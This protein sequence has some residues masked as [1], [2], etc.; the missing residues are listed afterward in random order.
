MGLFKKDKEVKDKE[1]MKKKFSYRV[2]VSDPL[3]NTTRDIKTF[4][5]NKTRD[6]DG[7]MWLTNEK[8]EF[9]EIFP[10]DIQESI[11]YTLAEINVKIDKLKK[12]KPKQNE[13][14]LNKEAE[15]FKLY[16]MQRSLEMPEGSFIKI[17]KDGM[18]HLEYVRYKSSFVPL[19]RNL[20]FKTVHV[21]EEPLVK[22]I[23]RAMA[24]K[25]EK[26]K[27]NTQSIITIGMIIFFVLNM[28][29]TGINIFWGYQMYDQV[30]ESNVQRL[31]DR[32]DMTPVIC[33]EMYGK[34]G[35]NFYQSSIFALNTTQIMYEKVNPTVNRDI[36]TTVAE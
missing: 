12:E 34:A 2:T 5:C 20:D 27:Q 26:Y 22:N 25:K 14:E 13:N 31:Q 29:H 30:D 23:I 21:P 11:P 28:V 15:L 24:E 32:I 4:G 6:N 18:P 10:L 36:A 3:A 9:R 33:A 8:E 1:K 7:V 35:E 17:D 19:K 16:K